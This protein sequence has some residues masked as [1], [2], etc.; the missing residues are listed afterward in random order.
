MDV[1]TTGRFA[2]DDVLGGFKLHEADSTIAFNGLP[3]AISEINRGRLK[4]TQ[5]RTLQNCANFLNR[6]NHMRPLY[7]NSIGSHLPR[8]KKPA[9]TEVLL[10]LSEHIQGLC[11]PSVR[12][13]YI[14]NQIE[15]QRQSLSVMGTL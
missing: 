1:V 3:H 10:G 12:M 7:V 14:N 4:S 5:R 9:G 11:M 6:G 15:A 13:E 8:S 2:P